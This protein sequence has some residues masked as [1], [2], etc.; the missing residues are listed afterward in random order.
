MDKGL[1]SAVPLG[2]AKAFVLSSD[3][4]CSSA[5][6]ADGG[7]LGLKRG[8]QTLELDPDAPNYSGSGYNPQYICEIGV[9]LSAPGGNV[10]VQSAV[11]LLDSLVIE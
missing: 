2:L 9:E 8:W 6:W 11:I 5:V 7:A 4:S 3:A 1:R 10:S